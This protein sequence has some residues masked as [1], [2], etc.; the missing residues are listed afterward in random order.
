MRQ[1]TKPG[2]QAEF[3]KALRRAQ[4]LTDGQ[5]ADGTDDVFQLIE[6]SVDRDGLTAQDVRG[7]TAK[8][9][10]IAREQRF[11]G[12]EMVKK[13]FDLSRADCEMLSRVQKELGHA[14]E[15]TTIREAIRALAAA[16]SERQ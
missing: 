3:L 8:A 2:K 11:G 7:V 6:Q 4:S 5:L 1:Y 16:Q 10:R 13:S 12:F 14:T 9:L 15:V